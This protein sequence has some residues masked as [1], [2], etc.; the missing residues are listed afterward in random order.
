MESGINPVKLFKS[1]D[2][3]QAQIKLLAKSINNKIKN[4]RKTYL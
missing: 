1:L 2:L 4:V 3:N